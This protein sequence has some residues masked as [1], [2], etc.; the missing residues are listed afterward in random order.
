MRHS[1]TAL[2]LSVSG[3]DSIWK[4]LTPNVFDLKALRHRLIGFQKHH[5]RI[6]KPF[7]WK[8]RRADLRALLNKFQA[9]A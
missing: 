4:A 5:E 8:L 3:H 7:E 9:A 2:L 1:Q 6:V